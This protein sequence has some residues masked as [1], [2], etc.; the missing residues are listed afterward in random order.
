MDQFLRDNWGGLVGAVGVL[1]T[2]WTLVSARGARKAAEEASSIGRKR[3]LVEELE[4]AA[5]KMGQ[6]GSWVRDEKW[7][8]VQLRSQ[9]VLGI[10]ASV[11]SRWGDHLGD[12][13]NNLRTASTQLS[14]VAR[15]TMASA[16][17][18][19]SKKERQS[20]FDAQLR[21][22]ELINDVLGCARRVEERS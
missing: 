16:T 10:S 2:V 7:E 1:L 11:L 14:S 17:K 9:E 6:V 5:S 4:D 8:L 13:A 20:I 3:N 15:Q 21:A 22:S 12:S 18:E 19:L